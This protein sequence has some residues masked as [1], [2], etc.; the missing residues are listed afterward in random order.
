[1]GEDKNGVAMTTMGDVPTRRSTAT[2]TVPVAPS[3]NAATQVQTIV[4]MKPIEVRQ[5]KPKIEI[6]D[7]LA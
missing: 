6:K 3:A 7:L 4:D 5:P 1:M 2:E